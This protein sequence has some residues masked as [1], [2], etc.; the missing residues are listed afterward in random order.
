MA[1][2]KAPQTGWQGLW[3]AV[4]ERIDGAA[5]FVTLEDGFAR[6]A[7]DG[8]DAV[9]LANWLGARTRDIGILAGAPVNFLEPFH[10]STAIATLDY[11][12]E[13]RAGLLVQPLRGERAAEAGRVIG[14]LGGFPAGDPAALGHDALDAV[15][16]IRRL[17]DSWEDDAVI[18]DPVSQRFLDGAKLHS[19]DFKGAGFSVLGPSITPRPPQGQPVVATTFAAGDDPALAAAADLVFLRSGAEELRDRIRGRGP[20]SFADVPV[21]IAI[22]GAASLATQVAEWSAAG[23]DGVRFL[24]RDLPELVETLLPALRQA[25]LGARGGT[26]RERLGLPPAVNRYATAA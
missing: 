24:P 21:D 3:N 12:T 13:G 25:G 19:I 9:L 20:L 16:V 8:P 2:L 15:E 5:D 11:V 4:V 7:G 23:F 26:L 14:R 18:R 1:A 10:V 6:S 17:W 22:R